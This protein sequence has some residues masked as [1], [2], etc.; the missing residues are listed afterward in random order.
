MSDTVIDKMA[1]AVERRAAE[2]ARLLEQPGLR[3]KLGA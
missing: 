1:A 2:A 3:S